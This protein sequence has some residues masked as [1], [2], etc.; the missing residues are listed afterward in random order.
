MFPILTSETISLPRTSKV[1]SGTFEGGPVENKFTT[2]GII[3]QKMPFRVLAEY[4]QLDSNIN[5]YKQWKG[6]MN[7]NTPV[8]DTSRMYIATSYARKYYPI[9]SSSQDPQAYTEDTAT[10]SANIQKH[11]F[12][13]SLVLT[14]GGS[15]SAFMGLIKSTAYSL[16]SNLEW[17]IGKMYMTLGASGYRS[18]S[19]GVGTLQNERDHEYYYVNIKRKLF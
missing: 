16:N 19:E 1:L 11:F 18:K 2:A 5:P 12:E 4:Q 10:F 6:E 15:Y 13:R 7:C 3:F 9:G 8:T 14:A 17:K